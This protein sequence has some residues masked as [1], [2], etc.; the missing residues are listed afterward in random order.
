MENC[1]KAVRN[2]KSQIRH[3]CF[4]ASS[5]YLVINNLVSDLPVLAAVEN[6]VDNR[7]SGKKFT[8]DSDNGQIMIGLA[9]MVN[10]TVG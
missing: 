4:A 5:I 1:G 8:P 9:T 3:Q 7:G 10:N 2:S 6:V